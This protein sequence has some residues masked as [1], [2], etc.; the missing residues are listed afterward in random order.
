MSLLKRVGCRG[1]QIVEPGACHI[2]TPCG[3][4]GAQVWSVQNAF[5]Q[6]L[7]RVIRAFLSLK[8]FLFSLVV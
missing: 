6:W 5:H 2:H 1:E 4:T 7:G 8:L 3:G